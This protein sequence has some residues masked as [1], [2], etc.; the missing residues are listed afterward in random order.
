MC[1]VVDYFFVLVG[2]LGE[3]EEVWDGEVVE[4]GGDDF[5]KYIFISLCFW[6]LGRGG[7]RKRGGVY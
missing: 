5:Y 7:V 1:V 4:D 2:C 6:G 3:V